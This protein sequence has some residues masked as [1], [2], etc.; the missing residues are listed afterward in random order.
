MKKKNQLLA[1]LAVGLIAGPLVAQ[2]QY[3]YEVFDHPDADGIQVFGINIRGD[4]VGN[5][6][7]EGGGPFIYASKKGE[8]TD[9]TPATGYART[10]VLGITDSGVMVGSVVSLDE[11]KTN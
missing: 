6:T 7:D 4:V 8:F 5:V 11:S 3:K 10:S 2:A 9:V 1:A